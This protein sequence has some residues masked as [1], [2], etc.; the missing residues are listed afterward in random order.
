MSAGEGK[1]WAKGRTAANDTRIANAA[2]AHRGKTYTR[3]VPLELDGRLRNGLGVFS[4]RTLELQWSQTMAY[5]VGLIAT[6]GCLIT[7][8]KQ[9]NFK[10]E[11]EQLVKTFLG[12]LGRS[13][14]YRRV[15]GKKGKPHHV[16]QFGDVAFYQ[17]L[18]TAGLTPKK[19]L[20]LGAITVPDEFLVHCARGLLDGDGSVLDYW[21]DGTGKALGKRYEGF[22]TRFI[23]AS[24]AHIEWLRAA[25]RRV[26]GVTGNV[27]RP[28]IRGCWSLNYAI[29]E[30]TVLLPLL[31]PSADVPKLER[32]WATWVR[33]ATR[34]GHLVT[35][36]GYRTEGSIATIGMAI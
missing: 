31:Y 6:D 35:G 28:S 13:P 3:H 21:Y 32:K 18:M 15:I 14:R 10:S 22:V 29:A 34:H 30:S 11:D 1:G 12:C 24:P 16:T 5:V 8:R 25:L 26:V 20:T 36:D 17:W 9:L 4:R 27:G 19:S 33:Y 2:A 23:S 7:A